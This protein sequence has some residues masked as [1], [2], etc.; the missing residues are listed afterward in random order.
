MPPR[1]KTDTSAETS[2]LF[3][4]TGSDEG[5]TRRRARELAIQLTPKEGGDFAVDTID[6]SA[7]NAEQ[8][9]L[10]IH[11]VI[12]AIQ[13]LPFFGSEKLVWL[14]DANFLADTVSARAAGVQ[15]ALEELKQFLEKGLPDGVFFLVSAVE[16]D[17]RR[18][19]F[20]WLGK[21][22]R[23]EQFDKLDTT[24]I[25][26]EE[27]VE[28][29]VRRLAA[30]MGLKFEAEALQLFVRLA[31]ADTHQLRNELEKL[32]LYIGDGG[33]VTVQIVRAL[34]AK[35]TTGVIWDL[36]ASIS[37]RQLGQSLS[38]LDQLLFQGETPIGILYAAIIPTVRNLLMAKDLL[39]RHRLRPPQTHYQ[40]ASTIKDLPEEAIR[41]LPRKK[42]GTINT[43]GLGLVAFDARRF[44]LQEL[45]DGL[46]ACLKANV[47]LVTTQLDPR[48]VLS[49]LLIRL[50]AGVQK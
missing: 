16:V 38:L 21:A 11:Q 39:I 8:A 20:K 26:W 33:V 4:V 32:D 30:E 35:S 49:E 12:E 14:K 6:G 50:I 22:F 7:D 28:F 44:E 19:F 29:V 9:I 15:A 2:R 48:L 42:D 31:G 40:F 1:K 5:E 23:L 43:Y 41:H 36:G 47:R 37:K 3:A 46:E 24:R 10:R 17:K 18:A 25:G 27:D 34:V 45:I 13:T